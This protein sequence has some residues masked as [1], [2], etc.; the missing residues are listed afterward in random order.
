[1]NKKLLIAG[2]LC[3]FQLGCGGI[4]NKSSKNSKVISKAPLL[5][6]DIPSICKDSKGKYKP[7]Q[8]ILSKGS[9]NLE[10]KPYQ[11]I[12]NPKGFIAADFNQDKRFDLIFIERSGSDIRLVTCISTHNSHLR[13]VTSFKVH[14]TIQPDFQTISEIIKFKAGKL[15]LIVNKHEHNWGSDSETRGYSYSSKAQDF[16][17]LQQETFSSSGDGMRSDT[18]EFYDLVKN[19]YKRSNVCGVME[20][21]CKSKKVSGRIIP[22]RMRSTLLKPTKTYSRLVPD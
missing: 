9:Y 19:R 14:E 13:K 3:I 4:K 15:E 1:M 18:E 16:I 8:R 21:G 6:A 12:Q 2:I 22:N 5:L 7:V 10:P 17:L 11:P 20:Q